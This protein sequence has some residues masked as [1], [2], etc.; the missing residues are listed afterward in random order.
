MIN[1]DKKPGDRV[2]ELGCGDRRHP[3]ADVAV[4]KRFLQGVTDF[5]V[6]LELPFTGEQAIGSDE[7]DWVYSCWAFEHV[8]WRNTKQLLSETFRVTKP[9]GRLVL[10]LPNTEAQL[11]HI[12]NKTEPDDDEGSMLFGGQDYGDNSHKSYWCP[13]SAVKKLSEV[14]FVDI[15]VQPY[16]YLQTDM[17][18]QATKPGGTVKL[19]N[20]PTA[21]QPAPVSP[22][23]TITPQAEVVQIRTNV[24]GSNVELITRVEDTPKPPPPP[25][26]SLFTRKYFDGTK[27][28]GYANRGFYW[29]FPQ[30]WML[31]KQIMNRSPESVLELGCGRGYVL[32]RLQDFGVKADGVDIS[33]HCYLTRACDGIVVDDILDSAPAVGH[34]WDLLFSHCFL[35]HVPE[36]KLKDLFSIWGMRATRGLHGITLEGEDD[37]SDPTRCTIR[38]KEWWLKRLP[39]G[40]EVFSKNELVA[41][42][43]PPEAVHDSGLCKANIGSYMTMS[44]NGWFNTDL[45]DLN[46]FAHQNGYR[47][48]Q[49]DV[50]RGLPWKTG[51]VDCI[52]S[53]HML[54]HLSYAQGLSFLKDCRR[55]IKP[56]TGVMRILVPDAQLLMSN[57]IGN[58]VLT[59]LNDFDEVS[60]GC[61]EAPT[62]A[63]K[64]AALLWEGH[65]SIYDEETLCKALE[66]AHFKPMRAEFRKTNCGDLGRLIVREVL[67]M[68][69]SLS[70]IVEAV[71]VG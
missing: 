63:K 59:S 14:G 24:L 15:M 20:T 1:L 28:G 52:V 49:N 70:L 9:G 11:K 7:F 51:E 64:L 38:S 34:S 50:T 61:A 35:E 10:V 44:H 71:P 25:R 66:E 46:Q 53:C 60:G 65:Q 27:G 45:H 5:S 41:G 54:E 22:P 47:F 8:S 69:P 57:Y 39:K 18:V 3:Q 67:E 37:G 43:L 16:G 62:N 33:K 36:D 29:D 56:N 48:I 23:Q 32:K 2:L 42:P 12:L 55:V 17:V 26:A 4:D 40:H 31:W 68:H 58:D 30:N 19:A 13:R 6:D 21:V